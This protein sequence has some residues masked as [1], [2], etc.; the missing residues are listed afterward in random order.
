MFLPSG[1][2]AAVK[3]PSDEAPLDDAKRPCLDGLLS[4]GHAAASGGKAAAGDDHGVAREDLDGLAEDRHDA[5]GGEAKADERA[6]RGGVH[7]AP[8]A[9]GDNSDRA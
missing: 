3:R 5:L 9:D 1:G 2:K 6:D 7:R 8:G 4:S